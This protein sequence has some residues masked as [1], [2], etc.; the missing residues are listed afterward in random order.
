MLSGFRHTALIGYHRHKR[1]D[2]EG[3]RA[4]AL[5][6]RSAEPPERD[7]VSSDYIM[8]FRLKSNDRQLQRS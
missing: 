7:E 2:F 5:F 3:T 8:T 4:V 1:E 6:L